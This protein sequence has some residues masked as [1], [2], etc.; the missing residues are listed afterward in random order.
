MKINIKNLSDNLKKGVLELERYEFLKVGD[1]GIL[2]N[3]VFGDK[4]MV[5]KDGMT[6]SV[7]YDSDPHFYMALVRG[8]CMVDGIQEIVSKVSKLGFM[9]DCSRNAVAKPEMVKRLVCMLVMA[10]YNYLELYTED[11]YELPEEPYFG[12]KRGRYSSEELKEICRFANIFGVEMVPCIQTLAHLDN[13]KNWKPYFDHMDINDILLVG[14]ERTYNLIRKSLRF[15]KEV[16]CTKRINI[17]TD[18]AFFLGRGKYIDKNGYKGKHEI[19]IE[20]LKRVFEICKEEDL[21]PE[22]WAETFCHAPLPIEQV[23]A[24]FD[25]TQTPI[26]WNYD[27]CDKEKYRKDLE[28][29]KGFAGKVQYAGGFWKFHG[30]APNNV[31]SEAA[32]EA[33]FDTALDCGVD[34]VL[35]T[36][37]G[38]NGDECSVFAILPAMWY[39]SHKL[40]PCDVDIS[41]VV[42]D[43]T[44]Y[45]CDEWKVADKLNHVMEENGKKSNAVKY[46]LHN[47]FLIGLMDY[48]IP[49]HAGTYYEELYP[50]IEELSKRKSQFAYI[51]KSYA[52]L[53]YA[54][55]GK[56]TY[57]KR[58]Y[59]AYQKKDHNA[60]R[61]M[62]DELMVIKEALHNFYQCFRKLWMKE[63]KGFGFEVMDVRIGGLITRIDTV[64]IMLEEYL[65]G[66]IET[67]YELEEERIE[68]FCGQLTGDDVY[69][70]LHNYWGTMY[71]INHIE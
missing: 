58:L 67:I 63:N 42:D 4:V 21:E 31:Y 55:I 8:V 27:K 19:Y 50:I 35:M 13:L 26:Y 30:Y 18:E 49:D 14:D 7:V 5:R 62:K 29:L 10:G 66:D 38:D 28:E 32:I 56:A 40:Y 60:I 53:C 24:L 61:T 34:N 33:A 51:F 70:A 25:G 59:Q 23:T 2:I 3:A 20:H 48:N 22:F 46:M 36:A 9:L 68:Y 47:D 45:S 64:N 1:D 41:A 71:T 65:N 44:G 57:S 69:S 15:Y 37:W 54:L 39:A 12:Y 43:L 52:A 17:G 11:T 6:V 16:F